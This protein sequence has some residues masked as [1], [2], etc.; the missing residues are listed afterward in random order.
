MNKKMIEDVPVLQFATEEE[1]H[2]EL[3][4]YRPEIHARTVKG[5]EDALK[6]DSDLPVVVAYLDRDDTDFAVLTV[7]QDSWLTN[8]EKTLA[9]YIEVEE[10][11]TCP[12]V[13]SLIAMVEDLLGE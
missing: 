4:K 8:L 6:A 7:I 5:I 2:A 11:E 1:M 12:R 3:D 9:Y 10:Y 13:K